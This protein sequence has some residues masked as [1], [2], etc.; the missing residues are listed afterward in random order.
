MAEH[1]IA[2][3]VSRQR[4]RVTVYRDAKEFHASCALYAAKCYGALY[5]AG[6]HGARTLHE[7]TSCRILCNSESAAKMHGLRV[8]T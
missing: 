3:A 7:A 8:A 6:A 1:T 5:G 2:I 4:S